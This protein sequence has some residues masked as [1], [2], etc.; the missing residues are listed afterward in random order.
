MIMGL[1][2]FE[3]ELPGMSKIAES[4]IEK[5]I[6]SLLGVDRFRAYLHADEDMLW[7]LMAKLDPTKDEI[8]V[9]GCSKL[10][11]IALSRRP[12]H[13]TP[14]CQICQSSMIKKFSFWMPTGE[15]KMYY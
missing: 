7:R 9:F 12:A 2:S 10:N 6:R 3:D 8:C 4:L 15:A 1:P 13:Y 5:H 11:C 14:K